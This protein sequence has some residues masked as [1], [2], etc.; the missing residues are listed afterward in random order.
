MP[1]TLDEAKTLAAIIGTA[2]GGCGVCVSDLAEKL[3]SSFP[4]F[5]FVVGNVIEPTSENGW[6]GARHVDVTMR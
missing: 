5:R 4:A 1:L 6:C 2:D 3:N